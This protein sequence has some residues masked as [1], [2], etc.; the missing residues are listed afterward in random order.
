MAIATTTEYKTHAK[1]SHSGM[2]DQIAMALDESESLMSDYLGVD[3][4]ATATYT[5]EP[6]SGEGDP[7]IQ[8]RNWPVSDV[9]SVKVRMGST[10]ST[11]GADSYTYSRRGQLHME[12]SLAA[13]QSAYAESC[14]PSWPDGFSNVLVTY[15][16]G[17]ATIPEGLKAIQF[18]MVDSMLSSAGRDPSLQ[19]ES[20]ESYS[21]SLKPSADRWKDWSARMSQYARF[22]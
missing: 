2:D 20:I 16:A 14:G 21:Y 9:S 1:I 6:Y 12:G 15:T 4:F 8:L 17:Y 3:S 19:S 11:L 22:A 10:T 5:D 18:E 13:Y 7:N